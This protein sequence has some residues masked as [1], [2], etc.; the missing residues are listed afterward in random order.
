MT[1]VA[2]AWHSGYGH[3]RRLAEAL[4]EGASSVPGVRVRSIDVA[5]IDASGWEALAAADAIVFGAP[6][7]MG[8]PS[9]PFKAF[10]DSTATI[11]LTQG[12]RDKIAAGFTCSLAMSGDKASTLGYFVTLAMQHGMIWVGLG[13]LQAPEAGAPDAVNRIGSYT[14]LMAQADNA[15]PD[16][17]PP[18]GDLDTAY[19]YGRRIAT[20]AKRLRGSAG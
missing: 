2:I 7:Y 18:Q 15:P 14:G 4:D 10:A 16:E 19:A 11:W 12:W 13:L 3:T 1:T 5:A 9:S 20:I 17:S 6:T 8:G